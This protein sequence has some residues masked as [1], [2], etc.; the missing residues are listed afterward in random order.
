MAF[1]YEEIYITSIEKEHNLRIV[2]D[3]YKDTYHCFNKGESAIPDRTSM[4]FSELQSH[5]DK[6]ERGV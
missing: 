6:A 2:H 3:S 1:N 4:T 5:I